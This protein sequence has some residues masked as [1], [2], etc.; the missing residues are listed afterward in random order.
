MAVKLTEHE[1]G[2]MIDFGDTVRIERTNLQVR[3][4]PVM[5]DDGKPKNTITGRDEHEH[6]PH[7]D[8]KGN[9][10]VDDKG[11]PVWMWNVYQLVENKEHPEVKG[12]LQHAHHG[13]P[14]N[15]THTWVH[16]AE[17]TETEARDKARELVGEK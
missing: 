2:L 4:Q 7:V 16:V 1:N 3:K 12:V 15:E 11:E 10:V 13:A 5:C 6:V 9:P 8:D 17:G 14:T